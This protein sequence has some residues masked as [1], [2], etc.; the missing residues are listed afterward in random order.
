VAEY[1]ELVGETELDRSRFIVSHSIVEPD[2]AKFHKLEN[3][4]LNPE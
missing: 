4:T 1:L 3:E 2:P